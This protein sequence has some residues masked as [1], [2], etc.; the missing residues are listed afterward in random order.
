M[1]AEHGGWLIDWSC[2]YQ[3]RCSR[4]VLQTPS[5][6]IDKASH[7]FPPN[8]QNS[9]TPKPLELGTWN[10]D[11]MFTTCHMSCVT[12]N[13]FV[14]S[15]FSFINICIFFYIFYFYCLYLIG[16]A[17]WWRVCYQRGLLRLVK[18]WIYVIY[19]CKC[20]YSS[21]LAK[22]NWFWGIA[23]LN[24]LKVATKICK[25]NICLKI[26]FTETN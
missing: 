4:A 16:E 24:L 20:W 9:I 2:I 3:T 18:P 21:S 11:T 14:S 7:P 10:I 15:S 6:L 17:C 22:L 5:S 23:L 12:C 13:I 8:L 1:A 19:V 26:Y 25:K